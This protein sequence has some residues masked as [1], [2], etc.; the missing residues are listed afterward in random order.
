MATS[1]KVRFDVFKRDAFVCQYCGQGTPDII[2]EVD[3]IHPKSQGGKD[4][5]NNLIT[6]CFDCNRG[7]GA[8]PLDDKPSRKDFEIRIQGAGEASEQL[9]E[10]RKYLAKIRKA[11]D[12]DVIIISNYWEEVWDGNSSFATK[13][14]S[15]IRAFLKNHSKEEMLESIDIARSR[16]DDSNKCFKYMCGVLHNKRRARNEHS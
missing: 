13:G 16:V 11:E 1:R 5:I 8:K 4:D 10:Y 15:D 6:A 9:T 12:R 14:K 2:L 3:H 7:K